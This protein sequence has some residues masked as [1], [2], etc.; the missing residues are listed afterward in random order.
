MMD[1]YKLAI[2]HGQDNYKK[3]IKIGQLEYI[4]DDLDEFH[5]NCLI[6][7]AKDN[8]ENI[9]IFHQ[10]NTRHRPEV[11]G[12]LFLHFFNDIIFFNTTKNV[13]KYGYSGLFL[14][15]DVITLEQKKT[16]EE[17]VD[18]IEKYNVSLF[19]SL[20]LED[21]I[22]NGEEMYSFDGESPR[23]LLDKYF[24]KKKVTSKH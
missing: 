4:E 17:F 5:S 19:C 18:S 20:N 16:L 2:I 8:Y 13:D 1:N 22:L 3:N 14:L 24:K 21:G 10:L 12:F 11:I 6:K 15:P 9:D 7:Y 23:L